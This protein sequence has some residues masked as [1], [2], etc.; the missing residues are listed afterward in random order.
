[1]RLHA[2]VCNEKLLSATVCGRYEEH[3]F[4]RIEE[5]VSVLLVYYFSRRSEREFCAKK[6]IH[7]GVLQYPTI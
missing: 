1:M 4:V 3:A 7:Y 2:A 6:R 5:Q